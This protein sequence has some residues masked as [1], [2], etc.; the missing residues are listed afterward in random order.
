MNVLS[1]S[2]NPPR[3]CPIRKIAWEGLVIAAANIMLMCIV[4]SACA[5]LIKLNQIVCLW[6]TL[7]FFVKT[8]Y[9]PMMFI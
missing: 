5:E 4:G 6:K 3:M 8:V 9:Q 7:F 1:R 2:P